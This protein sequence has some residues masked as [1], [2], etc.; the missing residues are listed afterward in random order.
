VDPYRYL[1]GKLAQV[2]VALEDLECVADENPRDQ[3]M[4]AKL[5]EVRTKLVD[6]LNVLEVDS[7]MPT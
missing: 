5:E 3:E 1:V 6:A 7:L 2:E 4:L